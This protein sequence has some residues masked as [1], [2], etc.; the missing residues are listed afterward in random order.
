MA[1]AAEDDLNKRVARKLTKRRKEGHQVTMEIPERFRD[2]DDADEDCTALPGQ[3]ANMNQSIF[4]MIAA[5]GSKVDINSRFDAQSSDE[6]DDPAAQ[7]SQTTQLP[8]EK[9]RSRKDSPLEKGHRR[10]LSDVKLLRSLSSLGA[11]SKS[12]SSAKDKVLSPSGSALEIPTPARPLDRLDSREA[13]VMGR[14]LEARAELSTRP[15]FDLPR[16]SKDPKYMAEIQEQ[17]SSHLAHELMKIF[18]FETPEDVID[19]GYQIY[20]YMFCDMLTCKEYPCC[21]LN[22]VLI[23]GYMYITTKHVC[24]YAYAPKESVSSSLR[25]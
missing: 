15:S 16:S 24:F 17:P 14:M 9:V 7:L 18:Q 22:S 11:R 5:A 2:G 19:G 8:G 13:P 4:G 12:K 6:E 20:N 10:K 21:L 3:N 25:R 23:R 1:P